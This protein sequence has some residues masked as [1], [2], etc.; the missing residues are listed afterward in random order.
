MQTARSE[1]D[2]GAGR[3][4]DLVLGHG[5]VSVAV[6]A[7]D[8]LVVGWARSYL[9]PWWPPLPATPEA[10]AQRI[11]GV[12]DA[13]ELRSLRS[14]VERGGQERDLMLGA[15][16]LVR[17]ERGRVIGWSPDAGVCYVHSPADRSTQVVGAG[18]REVAVETARLSRLFVTL[19]MA[20]ER[21][22]MLHAGC[23]VLPDGSGLLMPG[24]SG[25]GK[26]TASLVLARQ[27]GWLHLSSDMCLVRVGPQEQIEVVP[28]PTSVSLGLGLLGGLGW[29]T[30]VA[31][32]I[33]AGTVPHP[34]QSE[35]ITQRIL[36]GDFRPLRRAGGRESKF[37]LLPEQLVDWFGVQ[38]ATRAEASFVAHPA[39]HAG[40]PDWESLP[41]PRT[42]A[43]HLLPIPSWGYPNFLNLNLPPAPAHTARVAEYLERLPAGRF[44]T[45]HNMAPNDAL[46]GPAIVSMTTQT[47]RH[48]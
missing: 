23:V 34:A 27:P 13:A 7:D 20:G 4:T 42:V 31:T 9:G 16:G 2:D 10:A 12:V 26:T 48:P 24:Q 5:G 41:T 18:T 15:R 47:L 11:T 33:R 28:L 38:I 32:E 3:S 46:L 17:R 8:P 1:H 40:L 22:V 45:S 19:L 43:E 44:T 35:Q 29:G 21:W 36:T 39:V 37:E 30:R 6:C 25:A 14:E